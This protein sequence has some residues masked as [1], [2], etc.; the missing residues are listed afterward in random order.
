MNHTPFTPLL[1]RIALMALMLAGVVGGAA[2]TEPTFTE[3]Y[4]TYEGEKV[5]MCTMKKWQPA[6]I[7]GTLD[8]FLSQLEDAVGGAVAI[9]FGWS[10]M[11]A[12]K[13]GADN[14]WIYL[15]GS[16]DEIKGYFDILET[17]KHKIR[18]LFDGG[19]EILT[20]QD[21]VKFVRW[22]KND[23]LDIDK[24]SCVMTVE[25][26]APLLEHNLIRIGLTNSSEF[27]TEREL[28]IE[29]AE[30]VTTAPTFAA[31]S[32]RI[33]VMLQ[34]GIDEARD[35]A[36]AAATAAE[37]KKAE[38]Y[39]NTLVE[40]PA[41]RPSFPG[42]PAALM[43][44]MAQN[45]RYPAR[46]QEQGVQGRVMVEFIVEADGSLTN[47]RVV[48]S[49]SPDLDREALRLVSIMPRWTPGKKDGYPV[50][51]RYTYPFDFRLK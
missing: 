11:P 3:K 20:L 5:P 13:G 33:D 10:K 51:V 9:Q 50:R 38:Q 41:V 1:R 6:A 46:A 16:P 35:A 48:R 44:F 4:L 24:V 34:T 18:L 27:V 29:L 19:E 7:A 21:S 28:I 17:Y 30:E 49:V 12:S 2:Q 45:L 40:A 14:L 8:L 15:A 36:A 22:T 25:N 37:E 42:G 31:M 47:A 32:E 23:D 26:A 43:R 39:A